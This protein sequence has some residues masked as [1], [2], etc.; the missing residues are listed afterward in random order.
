MEISQWEPQDWFLG[1]K[2]AK[3]LDQ[4]LRFWLTNTFHL[5]RL[6]YLDV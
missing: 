6:I 5:F 2:E 3:Q 1:G 4:S